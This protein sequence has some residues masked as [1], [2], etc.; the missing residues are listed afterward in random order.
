MKSQDITSKT[1]IQTPKS[2]NAFKIPDS[3]FISIQINHK[4]TDK[5][6]IKIT[7]FKNDPTINQNHFDRFINLLLMINK[8]K[9]PNHDQI[10][11]PNLLIEIFLR[12]L[13]KKRFIT[14]DVISMPWNPNEIK[15]LIS[16]P[17]MKKKEESLKFIIR[18]TFGILNERYR[19]IHYFYWNRINPKSS[20]KIEREYNY[21]VGFTKFYF[22]PIIQRNKQ[23][24][25]KDQINNY[26]LPNK[27][28]GSLHSNNKSI[29]PKFLKR[30]FQ[31]KTFYHDFIKVLDSP[32]KGFLK[33][34]LRNMLYRDSEKKIKSWK[35]IFEDNKSS[36][37][38]AFALKKKVCGSKAK[39]PWF[40]VE[41]ESAIE[42]VKFHIK[43]IMATQFKSLYD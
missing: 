18:E 25:V 42:I 41:I 20:L 2:R 36:E 8:S 23:L 14:E 19:R 40:N 10:E 15:I 31:S 43:N 21:Y 9:I 33:K 32:E 38:L 7:S 3:K 12:I 6:L 30:I 24:G 16:A 35:I 37:S 39:L 11:L 5:S 29:T 22:G 13:I 4:F 26:T 34:S 28:N 27:K 1:Q 17:I